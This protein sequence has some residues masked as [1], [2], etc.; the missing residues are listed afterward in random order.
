MARK[1]ELRRRAERQAETRRRIVDAAIDLHTTVGPARTTLSAIAARAG[2]QRHTLYA[3]F[4]TEDDIFRACSGD[5]M[6]RNA[7][8]DPE[9][10][11]EI[12]DP[13]ER[14]GA[15]LEQLYGWY[16]ANEG[17]I[18]NVV[19][20]REVHELTRRTAERHMGAWGASVLSLIHI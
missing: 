1:Y 6:E 5:Y 8:P 14:L 10:W 13:W 12:A 18:G 3:H 16:A 15:A 20:D 4:P 2:V 17:M 11:R 9:R 7:P 19:R